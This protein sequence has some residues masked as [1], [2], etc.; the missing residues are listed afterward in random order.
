MTINDSY[1]TALYLAE[2]TD[3]NTG[4]IDSEYKKQH[5]KKAEIIIRQAI[6]RF[7]ALTNEPFTD[8]DLLKTDEDIPLL[9]YPVKNIIPYYV[10]AILCAHDKETD[11]Y[12]LL[13]YEYQNELEHYKQDEEQI[14]I[15]DALCGLE[16]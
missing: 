4:L 8:A 2:K 7:A 1:E 16:G 13:I 14:D 12:N 15:Y 5:S 9:I 6:R 10:A 11:K 3:D